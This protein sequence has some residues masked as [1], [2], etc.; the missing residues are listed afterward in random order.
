MESM[1][2][3]IFLEERLDAIIVIE[4]CILATKAVLNYTVLVGYLVEVIIA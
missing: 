3:I 1:V 2:F 4:Y